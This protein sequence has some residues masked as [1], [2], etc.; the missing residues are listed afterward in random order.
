MSGLHTPGPLQ[1]HGSHLYTADPERA[2]LAQVFNPGSSAS[3]YPLVANARRL[4]ACWNACDG[5]TTELLESN[6]APFSRL[7][8]ERDELLAAARLALAALPRGR[9]PIPADIAAQAAFDALS[10]ACAKTE[11]A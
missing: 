4:V 2:M 11:A 1:V 9:F 10:A 7:R 6:P 3:D 5:V 8:E